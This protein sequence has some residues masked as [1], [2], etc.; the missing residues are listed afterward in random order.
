M[1]EVHAGERKG[2]LIATAMVLLLFT[3]GILL[4]TPRGASGLVLYVGTGS[5]YSTIGAALGDA[6]E[7][8]VIVIASGNYNESISVGT[9]S[10]T[11]RGNDTAS[12]LISGP[13]GKNSSVT[14]PFVT[15]AG[16]TFVGRS[17]NISSNDIDLTG[18]GFRST[19]GIALNIE[20][21]KSIEIDGASFSG[22]PDICVNIAN[23]SNIILGK[24]ASD[25]SGSTI[26]HA[27]NVSNITFRDM[28]IGLGSGSKGFIISGDSIHFH[29]SSITST[30]RAS[31]IHFQGTDL[32]LNAM[33]IE[34]V[35]TA[36]HLS[37]SGI[38]IEGCFLT[39][40]GKNTH[41]IELS[42]CDNVTMNGTALFLDS[43]ARGIEVF[44]VRDVMLSNTSV[45][46]LGNGSSFLNGT[47]LIG[48]SI[49]D[50][51]YSSKGDNQTGI[52]LSGGLVNG[53]FLL[54]CVDMSISG[55][56]FYQGGNGSIIAAFSDHRNL[57]LINDIIM[58]SGMM[59]NGIVLGPGRGALLSSNSYSIR[60]D[61]SFGV[62]VGADQTEIRDST[63]IVWG[64]ASSGSILSGTDNVLIDSTLTSFNDGWLLHL[65]GSNNE[66]V[67]SQIYLNGP[68]TG[69]DVLGDVR[70]GV[71]DGCSIDLIGE[72]STGIRAG[73]VPPHT[74]N[75]RILTTMIHSDPGTGHS[76]VTGHD[77]TSMMMKD[78][79]IWSN[80]TMAALDLSGNDIVLDHVIVKSAGIGLE[81]NSARLLMNNSKVDAQRSVIFREGD[82]AVVGSDIVASGTALSAYEGAEVE[83]LDTTVSSFDV[84]PMSN[85]MISNTIGVRV[86]Y[87]DVQ[88][89]EGVELH[90]VNERTGGLHSTPY[91]GGSDPVTGP[92]GG[93]AP[94]VAL[95]MIYPGSNA[96]MNVRTNATVHVPGTAMIWDHVYDID[97]SAPMSVEL[98]VPDIDLPQSVLNL[99][100]DSLDT[101]ESIKLKWDPNDDDTI[102]YRIY[103]F[104]SGEW[105]LSGEVDHPSTSWISPEIGPSTRGIFR[106]SAF[107]GVWEGAPSQP[108]T[109]ITSDLTP[110]ATPTSAI[111]SDKGVD[112]LTISWDPG[113]ETDLEGFIIEMNSTPS[114]TQFETLVTL[115][116]GETSYTLGG[117]VPGTLYGFRMLAF[118]TSY[119]YSPYTPVFQGT[120][121]RMLYS[122][123]VTVLY[124][125]GPLSGQ[126]AQGSIVRLLS[127][128]GTLIESAQA[129][130]DGV[131][132]FSSLEMGGEY[133]LEGAPEAA[134]RGEIGVRSGY[135]SNTSTF[136]SASGPNPDLFTELFLTYYLRPETGSI[137]VFVAFGEGPRSGAVF[138]A[139]IEL[140]SMDDVVLENRTTNN[141]GEATF[142]IRTLPF[143]GRF[144]VTPPESVSAIPGKRAGYL[145]KMTNT[146]EVSSQEPYWGRFEIRLDYLDFTPPPRELLVLWRTPVGTVRDL[147][148]SIRIMFNQ[149]MDTLTIESYTTI[150]PPLK[151]ARY[152]WTNNNQSL[153]ILHDGLGNRVSY[154]VRIG[155]EARSIEGAGFPQGYTNN[156]WTFRTERTI[157]GSDGIPREVMYAA[158]AIFAIIII[159]IGVYIYIKQPRDDDL[160]TDEEEFDPYSYDYLDEEAYGDADEEADEDLE[161]E[162]YLED[163]GE[164]ED[165]EEGAEEEGYEDEE[166]LEDE[167]LEDDEVGPEVET[168]EEDMSAETPPDDDGSERATVRTRKRVKRK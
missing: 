111:I 121:E 117:L 135:L 110:P 22:S 90:V 74:T 160:G 114:M 79:I 57:T 42:S 8:D 64:E 36:M 93:I 154:T 16:M 43:G 10:V 136:I 69:I 68:G 67:Y 72:G 131:V 19:T 59:T 14:A 84:D 17:L 7:G 70:R 9:R 3:S 29:N 40:T 124:E 140:L 65:G 168:S 119:N 15:L 132:G 44:N 4:I 73:P 148:T 151:G 60:A 127:F 6:V 34:M 77:T 164:P 38:E 116:P 52:S 35:G 115:G 150:D 156:T 54:G 24:M 112:H 125:G 32:E 126:G 163:E 107:D 11:L 108:A 78:V 33:I 106:V 167:V 139:L 158:L 120:T 144:K 146:F 30:G 157:V 82:H 12:V 128:N 96:P 134:L 152:V 41:G 149:P 141:L 28:D 155:T 1:I 50:L 49:M 101:L 88:P 66:V 153:E 39:M 92:D 25:G 83:V 113:S 87:K 138:N 98:V 20:S 46:M 5:T 109:N 161:D 99:T 103:S 129:Q 27:I 37:G 95:K 26:C 21:S 145:Q 55:S 86:L 130:E 80:T 31:G 45:N 104:S 58:T 75:L 118:D 89:M 159:A 97:T 102:A 63:F 62:R 94:F 165:E 85:V 18:I 162:E 61:N 76:I 47:H 147:D 143:I 48:C 13:Y 105:I 123:E 91:F 100:A 71:I 51:S 81:S 53:S 56:N 122:L 2:K 137:D 166:D 142:S 133:R 23:S